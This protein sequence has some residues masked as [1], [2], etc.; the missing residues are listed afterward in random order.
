[1]SCILCTSRLCSSRVRPLVLLVLHGI[2]PGHAR[3][4]RTAVK[5]TLQY[6]GEKLRNLHQMAMLQALQTFGLPA[7]ALDNCVFSKSHAEIVSASLRYRSRASR[8]ILSLSASS[9]CSCLMRSSSSICWAITRCP[10]LPACW[11]CF[12]LLSRRNSR[13]YFMSPAVENGSSKSVIYD[14]MEAGGGT[15]VSKAF[16]NP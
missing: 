13:W 7:K 3:W 16:Q 15:M 6:K 9:S 14:T 8:S 5:R 11:S 12:S 2:R 4:M 1:M 10:R